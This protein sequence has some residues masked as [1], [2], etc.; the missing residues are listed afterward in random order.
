MSSQSDPG[1]FISTDPKGQKLPRLYSQLGERMETER[2]SMFKEAEHLKGKIQ[3]IRDV[4]STQQSYA[5]T[6]LFFEEAR[7]ETLVED[8]LAEK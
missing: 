6:G 2:N 1:D 4:I 3:I 8:A 5:K 7:M